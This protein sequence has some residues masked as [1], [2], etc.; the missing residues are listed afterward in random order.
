MFALPIFVY[1]KIDAL[2]AQSYSR[3][4]P[5]EAVSMNPHIGIHSMSVVPALY[6]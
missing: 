5:N 3:R 6:F 4:L 1:K 2:H